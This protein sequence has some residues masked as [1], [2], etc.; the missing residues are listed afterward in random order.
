MCRHMTIG[1]PWK[2]IVYAGT[3][4][5][6]HVQNI[7][8]NWHVLEIRTMN[9]MHTARPT[10]PLDHERWWW[11]SFIYGISILVEISPCTSPSGRPVS[12]C[13]VSTRGGSL[14]Q[15]E[16]P[17]YICN[18]SEL[19]EH[20]RSQVPQLANASVHTRRSRHILCTCTFAHWPGKYARAVI[21]E[22]SAV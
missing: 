2:W 6:V 15:Q 20:V 4:V 22:G 17:L 21:W 11:G 18:E 13:S 12:T 16:D 7:C 1:K 10:S 8:K 9:L 5:D 3:C 19:R 14:A